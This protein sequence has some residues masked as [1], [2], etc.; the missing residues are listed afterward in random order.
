[1]LI[2]SI[3]LVSLNSC[4]TVYPTIEPLNPPKAPT[5]SQTDAQYNSIIGMVY[6]LEAEKSFAYY[7]YFNYKI[8]LKVFLK[9][10]NFI[11]DQLDEINEKL[12]SLENKQT[13]D[14]VKKI[15]GVN[16]DD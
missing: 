8:S 2:A 10:T 3:S 12:D 16:D 14:A 4:R 13:A 15:E 11:Q 1:M 9:E 6:K 7:Q 5:F